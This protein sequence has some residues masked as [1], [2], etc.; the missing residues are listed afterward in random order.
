[1]E[2]PQ[3][4]KKLKIELLSDPAVPCLGIYHISEV[5]CPRIQ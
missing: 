4:T 2:A 5:I 1:M 3:K